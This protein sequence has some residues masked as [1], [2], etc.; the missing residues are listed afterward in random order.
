MLNSFRKGSGQD[1]LKFENNK[2]DSLVATINS[3][4]STRRM[5]EANRILTGVNK[6]SA[7]TVHS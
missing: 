5:F 3:T 6:N 2:A 1:L 7:I 4:D